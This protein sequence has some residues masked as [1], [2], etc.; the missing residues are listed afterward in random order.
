MG[1]CPCRGRWDAP[2]AARPPGGAPAAAVLL[3]LSLPTA[4]WSSLLGLPEQT[5]PTGGLNH[6]NARPPSWRP[7][8]CIRGVRGV[9]SSRSREGGPARAFLSAPGAAGHP[10]CGRSCMTSPRS[11][12]P[13]SSAP[14]GVCV[15]ARARAC[16]S[17]S[18]RPL[19][20]AADQGP[21]LFQGDPIAP[22]QTRSDRVSRW[23]TSV[24]LGVRAPTYDVG[25]HSSTRHKGHGGRGLV[26]LFLPN[27]LSTDLKLGD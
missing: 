1:H 24:T 25:V 15:R 21:A 12:P 20:T 23:A 14:G 11:P 19:R 27:V 8:I 2:Y 6:R 7:G 13:S 22:N 18:R 3:C 4:G 26:L 16:A 5:A 9:G 17:S 10:G